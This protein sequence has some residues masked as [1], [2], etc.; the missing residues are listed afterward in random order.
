M[1]SD[2]VRKLATMYVLAMQQRTETSVWFD[3][4]G[5]SAFH[6]RVILNLRQPLSEWHLLLSE[7]VLVCRHENVGASC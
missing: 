3:D 1:W 5:I 6:S 7:S 2:K 4:I